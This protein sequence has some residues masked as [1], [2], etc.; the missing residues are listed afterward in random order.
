MEGT[1]VSLREEIKADRNHIAEYLLLMGMFIFSQA[2][3][4]SG[5]ELAPAQ[6]LNLMFPLEVKALRA[7]L[8]TGVVV[9]HRGYSYGHYII[10]FHNLLSCYSLIRGPQARG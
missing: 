10:F 5:K 7:A 2:H 9:T 4:S 6:A 8:G 1:W 3:V